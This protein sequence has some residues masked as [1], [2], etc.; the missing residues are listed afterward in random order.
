[1][2]CFGVCRMSEDLFL[3]SKIITKLCFLVLQ[4]CWSLS[5]IRLLLTPG[6]VAH[7]AALSMEFPRQEYWS[8]LPFLSPG[9]LPKSGIEPVF[10]VSWI[11]RRILYH[12][13]H[14]GRL[15]LVFFLKGLL[16]MDHL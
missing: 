10:P 8:G 7:Q 5:C 4:L 3:V 6:A 11:G 13:S 9:D 15:Q 12:L 14:Q 1:M 16:H 2:E